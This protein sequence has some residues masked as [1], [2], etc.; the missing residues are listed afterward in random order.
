MAGKP[1]TRREPFLIRRATLLPICYTDCYD[2]YER[3]YV[4]VTATFVLVVV[5]RY[6][7]TSLKQT[8][9]NSVRIMTV[10]LI[11]VHYAL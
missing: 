9:S 1:L 6:L 8:T 5:F 4:K 10:F 7:A 3:Y 2:N 11:K